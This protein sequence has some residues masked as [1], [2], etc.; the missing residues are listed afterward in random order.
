MRRARALRTGVLI[1]AFNAALVGSM[2]PASATLPGVPGR[3]VF[4]AREGGTSQLYSIRGRDG[5][6]LRQ[7]T[8]FRHPI[9]IELPAV[10]PDGRLIAF[11]AG[12]PQEENLYLMNADGTDRRRLTDDPGSEHSPSFSPDGSRIVY[13]AD[14]GIFTIA[15][16]GGDRELLTSGPDFKPQY[17]PD[18][19][20]IVFE[21]ARGGLISAIW[22]MDA[23]GSNLK[24]LTPARLRA[25]GPDVAPDGQHIV[26][27][28][29]ES[30]PLPTSLY[31]MDMDGSN[32]IRL[33]RSVNGHHDLWPAYSPDGSQI[34]FASDRAY[35]DLCCLEVWKMRADGSHLIP[36]TSNVTPDGCDNDNCVYPVWSVRAPP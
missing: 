35:P 21:S 28:S 13:A 1:V 27:F 15:L 22:S 3:I 19:S 29:N 34:V 36:L 11:D 4:E 18:G 6:R 17:T 24:R 7:L 5:L 23:D 16:D 33:T 26:F 12:R 30:Y 2:T 20:T 32:I 9:E 14:A 31:V 10:S 8:H 25:G